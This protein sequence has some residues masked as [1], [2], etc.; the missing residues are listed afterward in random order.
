MAAENTPNS[1][2]RFA[3][4]LFNKMSAGK[5]E[6]FFISPFSI[7]T[8]MAMCLAGARNETSTQLKE[9]LNVS[10]LTDEQILDLNQSYLENVNTS[11][12]KD[13]KISTA[14]KIYPHQGFQIHQEFIDLLTKKF[15]SEVQQMNYA[16]A[17]ESALT[18]NK[19]VAEKTSDKIKNLI[20]PGVLNDLTRLVLVNAIYFKG[21]WLTQ[22]K[23][24]QTGKEDFHLNDGSVKKIDMMRLYNKKFKYLAGPSG[25]NADTLELPYHGETVSMTIILPH[26]THKLDAVEK[27]LTPEILQEVLEARW[28]T[29]GPKDP[30]NLQLPKFKLEHKEEVNSI[31]DKLMHKKNKS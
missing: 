14:N 28:G 31:F 16:N 22:F 30:I 20:S 6:N 26:K 8:A 7:S 19:W 3:L 2:N 1:L 25:I 10:H 24:D 13:I 29:T 17:N 21:N 23:P 15:H 5:N 18:I 12:G 11:L 9:L 4:K 27:Q